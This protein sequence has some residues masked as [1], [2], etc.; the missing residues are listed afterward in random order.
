M[1]DIMCSVRVMLQRY[2]QFRQKAKKFDK[3]VYSRVQLCFSCSRARQ[4]W[5]GQEVP[6]PPQSMPL[7]R[8]IT[9]S[10][11]WPLSISKPKCGKGDFPQFYNL[12]AKPAIAQMPGWGTQP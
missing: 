6:L 9:S 1:T 4:S 7:R 2:K 5:S 11:F 12:I 3:F 8:A 10:I